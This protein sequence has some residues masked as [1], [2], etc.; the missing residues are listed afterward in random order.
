MSVTGELSVPVPSAEVTPAGTVTLTFVSSKKP[1]AGTKTARSPWTVQ[2][3]AMFGESCG[4]GVVGDSGAENC[5]QIGAA[6]LTPCAP[7]P[8]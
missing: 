4:N 8:G 1:P 6:P 2:L 3:P 7:A 5:T